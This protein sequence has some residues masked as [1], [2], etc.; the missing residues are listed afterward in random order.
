[1]K[2]IVLI[3]CCCLLSGTALAQQLVGVKGSW[4][5]HNIRAVPSVRIPQPQQQFVPG[6][7]AGLVFRTLSSRHLG[8]QLELLVEEKGYSLLPLNDPDN[9]RIEERHLTLPIQ[10]VVMVGRGNFQLVIN[11]GA[12]AS[13]IFGENVVEKAEAK[14]YPIKFWEQTNQDWHYGLVGGLGPA[15]RIGRN[16]LQLEARFSYSLSN[17]L[18]PNLSVTDAFNISNQQSISFSL[19]WLTQLGAVNNTK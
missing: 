19:Q 6:P 15:V 12:F 8:L 13:Y 17:R 7:G 10:S 3:Y 9:Y 18:K 1:M 2:Y 11:G 14:A 4:G 5:L 16:W